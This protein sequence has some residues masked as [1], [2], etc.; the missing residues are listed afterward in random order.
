MKKLPY[1]FD[2]LK[3]RIVPGGNKII[4]IIVIY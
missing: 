3:N 4:K 2:R 1:P